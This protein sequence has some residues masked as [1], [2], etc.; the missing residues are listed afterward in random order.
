MVDQLLK[1][2]DNV[3]V[4]YFLKYITAVFE[5]NMRNLLLYNMTHH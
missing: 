2:R 4:N 1:I 3:R 5:N